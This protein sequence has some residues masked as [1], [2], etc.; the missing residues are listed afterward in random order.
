VDI[1]RY[2]IYSEGWKILFHS[3]SANTWRVYFVL[4]PYL[5]FIKERDDLRNSDDL[6]IFS[7]ENVFKLLDIDFS[8]YSTGFLK[9]LY[10]LSLL[11]EK[12]STK[13]LEAFSRE[14]IKNTS[15]VL[16]KMEG[17]NVGEVNRILKTIKDL[18]D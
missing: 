6:V 15:D 8:Y 10:E 14:N 9:D 1:S 11:I 5:D 7:C 4:F 16:I 3:E 13:I 12:N 2:P 18:V 17:N